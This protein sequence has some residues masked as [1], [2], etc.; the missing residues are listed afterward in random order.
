MMP[1]L[2]KAAEDECERAQA[3]MLNSA[4]SIRMQDAAAGR[5]GCGVMAMTK[6]NDGGLAFPGIRTQQ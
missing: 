6:I 4:L 5:S 3:A 1:S 2:L